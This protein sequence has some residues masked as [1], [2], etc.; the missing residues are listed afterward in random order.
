MRSGRSWTRRTYLRGRIWSRRARLDRRLAFGTAIAA[1]VFG[2]ATVLV[3]TGA[4]EFGP[5][6][7]TVFALLL[8]DT[9]LLVALA[10][11]VV[12]RLVRVW[13]ARRQGLAGADLHVRIVILFSLVAVTPAILVAIFST[14][15]LHFGM[16]AWFSDRVRTAIEASNAV[17]HAYLEEYRQGIR[18]EAFAMANEINRDAPALMRNV[19]VF[20]QR[21]GALVNL[22]GLAEALVVDGSGRVLAHAPL[23]LSFDFAILGSD[24]LDQLALGQV[25]VLA[26]ETDDRVRALVKL[27]RFVDAYLVVG[28]FVD[29]SVSQHIERTETAVAQY[30]QFEEQRGSI[31][32]TFVMIFVIVALLLLLAA[33]WIGLN[34]ATQISS[35]ISALIGAAERVRGGDLTVRVNPSASLDAVATLGRT[36]NRMTSQ[37]SAQR[38][39]LMQANLDLDERRRFT[40]AVLSGVSA[41]VI[42]LDEQRLI[43][44]PNRSASELLGIDLDTQRGR[45]LADVVPEMQGLLDE[46]AQQPDRPQ[47]AEIRLVRRQHSY[48]LSVRIVAEKEDGKVLGYVVTFDNITPLVQAERKAAWADIARRIAH[49]IKNPLTPIQL[50]SER[51]KRKYLKEITSDPETFASLTETIGRRVEDIGRMVDEFSAF[52]RMPRPELK[53]EPLND[54]IRETVVLERNR[55][56]GITIDLDLPAETVTLVCDH[57]QITQALINL[58][59]N[60]AEAVVGRDGDGVPL[61]TGWIGVELWRGDGRDL[62]PGS[63]AGSGEATAGDRVIIT[64]SDNGRGLPRE[65]R[66]RLIEPYVTTRAKGTGLGLAIVKKIMEDHNGD[67]WLDDRAGGGA[68]VSLVFNAAWVTAREREA[69]ARIDLVTADLTAQKIANGL[70]AHG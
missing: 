68:R 38:H 21:L 35:P 4:T 34:F 13:V 7:T 31:L 6:P 59:K 30:R 33:V 60:A 47:R 51:L 12:R 63:G 65:N 14:M 41:G 46:A 3:W 10:V 55:Y 18:T 64:V 42:G 67:V 53:P 25:V 44:L 49:E 40:E 15:F 61:A 69:G 56:P 37:L 1:V 39:G 20:N 28:R 43:N 11:V 8:I 16:Q 62:E 17:A 45:P 54:L 70:K 66:E 36:F 27:N 50:A 58:M 48:T 5:A 26:S 19:P 32:I 9:L 52:A 57:R 29:P 22:R 2:T 23:S 24:I